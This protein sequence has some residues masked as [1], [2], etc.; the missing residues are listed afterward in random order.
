MCTDVF[1]NFFVKK[2][3]QL[4]IISITVKRDILRLSWNVSYNFRHLTYTSS[5]LFFR[6]YLSSLR[7]SVIGK[8]FK[9]FRTQFRDYFWT[10][11]KSS[12]GGIDATKENLFKNPRVKLAPYRLF[13]SLLTLHPPHPLS[14]VVRFFTFLCF[15]FFPRL[16]YVRLPLPP[17][18]LAASRSSFTIRCGVETTARRTSSEY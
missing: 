11:F 1:R 4:C 2:S 15:F 8:Q 10:W 17:A 12:R 9:E 16:T 14:A 3:I 5:I 13:L 7:N 6:C 18:F